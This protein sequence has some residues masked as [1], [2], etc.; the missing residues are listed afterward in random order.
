M[1]S[2]TLICTHLME[3][4]HGIDLGQVFLA[5]ESTE[6]VFSRCH[7]FW[8]YFGDLVQL[9]KVN[10]HPVRIIFFLNI[11][12]NVDGLTSL[13]YCPLHSVALPLWHAAMDK[14]YIVLVCLLSVSLCAESHWF[15]P[16]ISVNT[17]GFHRIKS[18]SIHL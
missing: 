10:T 12:G 5:T 17:S 8:A 2:Q 3:Q 14:A 1:E 16:G 13:A 7:G 11:R 18:Y 4:L 6:Q 9:P 15:F